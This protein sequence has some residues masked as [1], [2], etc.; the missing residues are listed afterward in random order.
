MA[1]VER[2]VIKPPNQTAPGNHLAHSQGVSSQ[3]PGT[4]PAN[5]RTAAPI[6]STA[7][8][9]RSHGAV[10]GTNEQN[11]FSVEN[12]RAGW[13]TPEATPGRGAVPVQA[14]HQVLA[15]ALRMPGR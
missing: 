11:K 9:S 7:S 13:D 3:P 2:G 6:G 10:H 15:S 4:H 1:N 14:G 12:A 5:N 8:L